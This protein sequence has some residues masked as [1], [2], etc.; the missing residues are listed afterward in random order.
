M[1]QKYDHKGKISR[2]QTIIFSILV[3]YQMLIWDCQFFKNSHL[4]G[5]V[6]HAH[7][8]VQCLSVFILK[9]ADLGSCGP[10]RP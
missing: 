8:R 4:I 2:E 9:G 5:K 10:V 1:C 3:T 7:A 6:G